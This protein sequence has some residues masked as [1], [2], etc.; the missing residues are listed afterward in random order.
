M[1]IEIIDMDLEKE[2]KAFEQIVKIFGREWAEKYYEQTG[3]SYILKQLNEK[4]KI[5]QKIEDFL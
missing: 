1:R 4:Q 2:R 3:R 5:L